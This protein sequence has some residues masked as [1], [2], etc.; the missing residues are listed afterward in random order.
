MIVP[1]GT[2]QRAGLTG[3]G[4]EDDLLQGVASVTTIEAS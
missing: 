3:L 4:I 2:I 1:K